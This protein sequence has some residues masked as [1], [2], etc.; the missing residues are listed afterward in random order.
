MHRKARKQS[1]RSDVIP[2][3]MRG[4]HS[5]RQPCQAVHDSSEIGNTKS[6]VN[7]HSLRLPAEQIAVRLFRMPVFTD[8]KGLRVDARNVKPGVPI[9]LIDLTAVS[10][11]AVGKA[12]LFRDMF[13]HGLCRATLEYS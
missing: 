13:C 1:V 2:V 7:Q 9:Q 4:E 8:D 10:L 11:L 3:N 6:R 5:E 12:E